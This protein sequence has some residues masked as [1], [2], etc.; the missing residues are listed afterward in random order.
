M[1]RILLVLLFFPFLLF[2]QKSNNEVDISFYASS[3]MNTNSLNYST[4]NKL[5][6]GGK[7]TEEQKGKWGD[8]IQENNRV[9]MK[10]AAGVKV[11]WKWE[12]NKTHKIGFNC[13]NNFSGGI[14]FSDVLWETLLYGNAHFDETSQNLGSFNYNA[15]G[16]ST[17]Q[18]AY[19]SPNFK[20]NAKEDYFNVSFQAGPRFGHRMINFTANDVQLTTEELA[21][22]LYLSGDYDFYNADKNAINGYGAGW[23]LTLHFGGSRA[24]GTWA[25]D[26]LTK[27]FGFIV[28]NHNTYHLQNHLDLAF[29][30][31]EIN[32]IFHHNEDVLQKQLDSLQNVFTGGGEYQNYTQ[33]QS[34]SINL[35]TTLGFTINT[36]LQAGFSIEASTSFFPKGFHKITL[37]PFVKGK[38]ESDGLYYS[39]GLPLSYNSMAGFCL[40]G[41]FEVG[42]R[43]IYGGAE[44]SSIGLKTFSSFAN[45]FLGIKIR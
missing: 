34:A 14:R 29:E 18:L 10:G 5:I 11:L 16:Y 22:A 41:S 3:E 36:E 28:W 25:L 26:F 4:L 27:G 39:V 42:N 20:L 6:R 30:G 44:V 7:I 32:N 38:R 31:F 12:K 17:L 1:K 24:F 45:L 35:K 13:V 33:W 2:A 40:G 19:Q 23:D 8:Y 37:A 21:Q 15:A 43:Q 9:R